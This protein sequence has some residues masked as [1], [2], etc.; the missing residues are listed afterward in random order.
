MVKKGEGERKR[1]ENNC[2]ESDPL[3]FDYKWLCII[4]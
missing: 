1:K 4:L 3:E 2:I